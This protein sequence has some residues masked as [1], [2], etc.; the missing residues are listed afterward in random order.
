MVLVKKM[1]LPMKHGYIHL[2]KVVYT[3]CHHII[4]SKKRGY[5]HLKKDRSFI[6]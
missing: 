2:K 6:R 1:D 4:Q 5:I 3:L